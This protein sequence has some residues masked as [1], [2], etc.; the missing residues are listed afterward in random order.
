[1]LTVRD[2]G[3][4]CQHLGDVVSQQRRHHPLQLLR[5]Y[6]D[7][8]VSPARA[9][10]RG[11]CPDSGGGSRRISFGSVTTLPKHPGSCSVTP[12]PR[13]LNMG[14]VV[15]INAGISFATA[16]Q[17]SSRNHVLENLGF[18]S[19]PVPKAGYRFGWK[20]AVRQLLTD[21]RYEPACS[22]SNTSPTMDRY[23]QRDPCLGVSPQTIR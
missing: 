13:G 22:G 21:C 8:R 15:R 5:E 14:G 2:C 11:T 9:A 1:M 7:G 12:V 3:D 23:R 10:C 17:T 19:V 6:Q 16:Y 20:V 4:V 18:G